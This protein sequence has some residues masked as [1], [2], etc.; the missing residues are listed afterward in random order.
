MAESV[1]RRRCIAHRELE[2]WREG[3]RLRRLAKGDVTPKALPFI[4]GKEP[5][6][7]PR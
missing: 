7:S 4:P 2:M 6:L 5:E 1:E 3:K